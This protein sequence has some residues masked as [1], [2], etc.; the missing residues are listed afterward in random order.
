VAGSGRKIANATKAPQPVKTPTRPANLGGLDE[1][2]VE[3]FAA[4]M[5]GCGGFARPL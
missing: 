2:F 1:D 5:L 3:G 4:V